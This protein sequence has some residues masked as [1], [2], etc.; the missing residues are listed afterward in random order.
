MT[1]FQRVLHRRAIRTAFLLLRGG[2]QDP[3]LGFDH[4]PALLATNA[5]VAG[6][7]LDE[8]ALGTL[9]PGAPA[10]LIAV[11]APARTPPDANNWFGHLAYG[12]SGEP[13]DKENS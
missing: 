6:R 4:L 8:P 10:D 2:A 11:D 9:T 7:F 5:R 1:Q 12:T 3:T 13:A